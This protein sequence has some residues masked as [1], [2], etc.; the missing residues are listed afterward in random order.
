M[1]KKRK[2]NVHVPFQHDDDLVAGS[3]PEKLALITARQVLADEI[4]A[5]KADRDKYKADRDKLRRFLMMAA[6][7]E[8]WMVQE[9]HGWRPTMHMA[10]TIGPLVSYKKTDP[11]TGEVLCDAQGKIIRRSPLFFSTTREALDRMME[12]LSQCGLCPFTEIA[13]LMEEFGMKVTEKG[14][15]EY[16]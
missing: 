14:G 13:P 1:S 12:E 9:P 11:K 15:E 8:Q 5:L 2:Y 7:C 6:V 10:L 3:I 4:Q 16:T